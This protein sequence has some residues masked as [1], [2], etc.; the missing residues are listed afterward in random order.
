[1]TTST[2]PSVSSA[3]IAVLD[4]EIAKDHM[5]M[6]TCTDYDGTDFNQFEDN[7]YTEVVSCQLEWLISER[8]DPHDVIRISASPTEFSILARSIFCT[9]ASYYPIIY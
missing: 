2:D 7:V 6:I 8:V 4:K 9:M 5:S 3:R 1:V